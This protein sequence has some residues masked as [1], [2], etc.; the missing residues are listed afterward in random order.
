MTKISKDTFAQLTDA[1]ASALMET[2][3]G[4]SLSLYVNL[5]D[6]TFTE[7]GQAIYK[8]WSDE[9]ESILTSNGLEK[10]NGN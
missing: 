3:L 8:V 7:D 10:D 1:I 6:G 5:R 4:E 9:A 2:E